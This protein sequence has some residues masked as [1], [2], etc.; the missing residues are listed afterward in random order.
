MVVVLTHGDPDGICSAA[1]LKARYPNSKVVLSRPVS[2]GRDLQEFLDE[3]LVFVCDVAINPS[4]KKELD[5][6]AE[7]FGKR[8]KHLDH[9]PLSFKGHKTQKNKSS[10]QIT[11]ELVGKD[12]AEEMY[13]IAVLGAIADYLPTEFVKDAYEI[14]GKELIDLEYS[15][16]SLG[17]EMSRS[18]FKLAVVDELSYGKFPTD[19]P[20]LVRKA[21][22]GVKNERNIKAFVHAKVEKMNKIAYVVDPPGRGSLGRAAIL[23]R[24][25]GKTPVGLCARNVH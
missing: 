13:L 19:I 7:Y 22:R 18:W 8:L 3:D 12:L 5:S 16:L 15:I 2:L 21:I 11:Y 17:L 20:A 4:K 14:W 23:A 1:L 25:Y 6:L 10:S 24:I 9:H